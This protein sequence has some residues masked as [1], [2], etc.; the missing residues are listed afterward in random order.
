MLEVAAGHKDEVA[1][2]QGWCSPAETV[3]AGWVITRGLKEP[4]D[5]WRRETIW[6]VKD[7]DPDSLWPGW[8]VGLCEMPGAC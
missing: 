3:D 7:P 5:T 1:N 2:T 4:G 8:K 6:T